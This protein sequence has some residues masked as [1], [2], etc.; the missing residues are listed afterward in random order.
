MRPE[1]RLP[2]PVGGVR[3]E[4]W[5]AACVYRV[6]TLVVTLYLIV[7]WQHLYAHPAVADLVGAAMVVVTALVT[8]LALGGRAH[9]VPVVVAD[10]VVTAALTVATIGAQT[11]AQRHGSMPTLTTFWAAG[12][13]LE[14]GIVML[15]AGGV[16]AGLVQFAAAVIVR[17]GVDGRTVGSVVLLVVAGGV[18][19]YVTS[20]MLR[21]EAEL[22][23]AAATQA[24]VRERERLARTV[25]DGVLQ[26][27]GLVHREGR[28]AGGRWAEL[29][30]LADEQETSL[31][32]LVTAPAEPRPAGTTDLVQALRAVVVDDAAPATCA[33]TVSA[34][35]H[36]VLLPSG[37]SAEVTAAATA[38]LSNV[39]RHAGAGARAWV[40]VEQRPDA[41]CVTVRDD[42]VGM[43]AGR[44]DE[45]ARAGRLG[46]AA[47]IRSRVAELGGAVT[48]TSAPGAGTCVE[49]TVPRTAVR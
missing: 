5:R 15:T 11:P 1:L 46:V 13:A 19:G 39:A 37:V 22:A 34:P 24:A 47:S 38:A 27:L 28:A 31:R 7:R 35:A 40:L 16:V 21:A 25:H 29:A 43:P 42:G 33:A 14:A 12:P 36:P 10:V 20:L 30:R 17:A 4:L 23:A 32:A 44:L 18:A 49:I 9:R 8:V 41:V 2:L 26:V 3:L 48:I 6:A 45:A